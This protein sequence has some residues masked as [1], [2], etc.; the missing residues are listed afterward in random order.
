MD[1]RITSDNDCE[2]CNQRPAWVNR[3]VTGLAIIGLL[4]SVWLIVN[5]ALPTL[6]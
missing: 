1:Q 3:L 2:S 4:I 5:Y 6:R